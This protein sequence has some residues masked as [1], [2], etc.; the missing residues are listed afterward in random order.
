MYF[1]RIAQISLANR[2]IC[3][4]L[5][6]NGKVGVGEA[7]HVSVR[8]TDIYHHT[9]LKPKIDTIQDSYVTTL[10]QIPFNN[11]GMKQ[12]H[13]HVAVGNGNRHLVSDIWESTCGGCLLGIDTP[14]KN[15][16]Q[17][18]DYYSWLFHSRCFDI[19]QQREAKLFI[20]PT[21]H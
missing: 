10:Y 20:S 11:V 7:H 13:R 15:K 12:F 16:A 9:Y 1:C 21:N 6:K 4:H 17:K 5:M 8:K 18:E 3:E 2:Y 14:N 19:N